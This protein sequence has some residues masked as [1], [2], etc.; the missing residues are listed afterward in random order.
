MCK[1]FTGGVV[2]LNKPI[3]IGA[4][5]SLVVAGG[6]GAYFLLD[7]SP[8]EEYFQAEINNYGELVENFTTDY[9]VELDYL[10][11]IE[12]KPFEY[13]LKGQFDFEPSK[14]LIKESPQVEEWT[15]LIERFA[16]KMDYNQHTDKKE[17]WTNAEI[18]VD[19]KHFLNV[20]GAVNEKELSVRVPDFYDDYFVIKNDTF[21]KTLT[22]LLG[23]YDGPE[24]ID[25]SV[26]FDMQKNTKIDEKLLKEIQK[27]Y[28]KALL[29]AVDDKSVVKEKVKYNGKKATELTLTLSNEETKSAIK[30]L[31]TKLKTDDRT[32]DIF[33]DQN[34]Y[35]ESI[36]LSKKE[37]EE[38][39]KETKESYIEDIES[40]IEDLEEV[41]FGKGIVSTI[42]IVDKKIVARH[43]ILNSQ[44][45]Y[46]GEQL[47]LKH[48]TDG[49]KGTLTIT[50]NELNEN[51]KVI[52]EMGKF[53]DNY[54]FERKD[55][56][57][58]TV[59]TFSVDDEKETYTLRYTRTKTKTKINDDVSLELGKVLE[60]KEFTVFF[61][62]D[63]TIKG[64]TFK[65]VN[66]YGVSHS[67]YGIAS[68]V[69]TS[70]TNFTNKPFHP[71]YTKDNS[72]RLEDIDS[73]DIARIQEEMNENLE[74]F[75]EKNKDLAE[76]LDLP[77]YLIDEFMEMQVEA[78]GA[79]IED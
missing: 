74:K 32:L 6:A 48:D 61:K 52:K 12:N 4:L 38:L 24:K 72:T 18:L 10:D 73:D 45:E 60:A 39:R 55:G 35:I 58:V 9:Q 2:M 57:F 16:L 14:Q 44:D 53:V 1:Y 79:G 63:T 40:M 15:D 30:T 28:A 29:N 36:G 13:S 49:I 47:V 69:G 17:A 31:L 50:K 71:T 51:G 26:L 19:N 66:K 64:D 62:R 42:T 27:D 25:V 75:V 11:R 67:E 41:N 7:K 22:N 54:T 46:G 21:G 77:T 59:H 8:K 37:Q 3:L 78:L 65:S 70:N 56:G 5:S 23:D 43:L 76:D 20:E 33:V 34:V 68:I